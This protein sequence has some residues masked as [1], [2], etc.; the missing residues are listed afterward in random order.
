MKMKIEIINGK[1]SAYTPYSKAFIAAVK[2]LDGEWDGGHKRWIVSAERMDDLQAAIR[3]VYG[4]DAEIARYS[5]GVRRPTFEDVANAANV[6]PYVVY[7]V[8]SGDA[9]WIRNHAQNAIARRL[10]DLAAS[11]R[12]DKKQREKVITLYAF[13]EWMFASKDAAWWNENT[14]QI[15][16]KHG[17]KDP[18]LWM[19]QNYSKEFEAYV[20][21][22]G[23]WAKKL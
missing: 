6:L 22:Q 5:A 10:S 23:G 21:A 4:E 18:L 19:L 9:H 1:A 11:S 3:N 13:A 8:L 15:D 17:A 12:G 16:P 7:N 14:A 20:A 2:E